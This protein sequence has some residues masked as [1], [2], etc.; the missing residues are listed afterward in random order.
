MAFVVL[1]P[2]YADLWSGR[3]RE[4]SKELKEYAQA[5][6]PGFACPEWVQVVR[7]LPVS[8]SPCFEA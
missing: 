3:D 4:F 2:Q 8:R 1:R 6:L 5:R 7:E